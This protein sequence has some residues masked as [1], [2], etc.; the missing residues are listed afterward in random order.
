MKGANNCGDVR[1][2]AIGL[3]TLVD[4][5]DR[6]VRVPIGVDAL[7]GEARFELLEYLTGHDLEALSR[8]VTLVR[9]FLRCDNRSVA[10]EPGLLADVLKPKIVLRKEP[11]YHS[12]SL[13]QIGQQLLA[14]PRWLVPF[15]ASR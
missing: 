3:Q 12:D 10:R 8:L 2:I 11:P 4:N 5:I 6:I 1:L 15:F 7:D 14:G 13:G 9:H